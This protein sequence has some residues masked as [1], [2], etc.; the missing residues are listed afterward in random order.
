MCILKI[1]DTYGNL[2][3]DIIGIFTQRKE[4]IQGVMPGEESSL[5]N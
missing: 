5:V 1:S 3:Y 2:E 4:I